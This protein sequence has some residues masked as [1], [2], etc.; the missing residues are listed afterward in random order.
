MGYEAE[1]YLEGEE[2]KEESRE[3]EKERRR[4]KMEGEGTEDNE[5]RKEGWCS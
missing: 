1:E 4:R 2:T 3:G 5:E